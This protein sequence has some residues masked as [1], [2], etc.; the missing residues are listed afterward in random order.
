[1]PRSPADQEEGEAGGV[2]Q[3]AAVRGQPQV[4]ERR[5]LPE[6]LRRRQQPVPGQVRAVEGLRPLALRPGAQRVELTRDAVGRGEEPA[7][8][9]QAALLGEEQEDDPHHHRDGGVVDLVRVRRERVLLAAP[10][11]VEASLGER[12]DEQLDRAPDLDA[13]R[14]GDLLGRRDRLGEQRAEPVRGPTAE[15]PP[16][17]EQLDE[18]VAGGRLL[19]PGQRVDAAG[20]DHGLRSGGD[21]RPPPA[22]GDDP[23]LDP[24]RAEQLLHP[25][26]RA[27]GPAVVERV[28]Q[29]VAGVDDEDQRTEQVTVREPTGAGDA[30]GVVGRADA[31]GDVE[32]TGAGQVGGVAVAPAEHVTQHDADPGVARLPVVRERVRVVTA[33]VPDRP[34]LLQRRLGL[35]ES[36][37][38]VGGQLRHALRP[39]P[40]ERG[41]REERPVGLDQLQPRAVQVGGGR[42]PS[43]RAAPHDPT[44]PAAAS[45]GVRANTTA[46][47][48]TCGLIS[49]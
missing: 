17:L 35:P 4:L 23:D 36:G 46:A 15:Q 5:A 32:E 41:H 30:D 45:P 6:R 31:G 39:D 44:R 34:R 29:C 25:V 1:M 37:Q 11:G 16:A 9:Q 38:G 49:A 10:A 20:G 19:D 12:L 40:L 2:E 8:R 24:G 7:L 27:G 26:D 43:G 3:R 21:D 22:V 47:A 18:R 28:A 14:L 33:L 48:E 42:R 13:E